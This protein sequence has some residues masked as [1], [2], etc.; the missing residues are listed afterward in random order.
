[1]KGCQC[2]SREGQY[3]GLPR[4][5]HAAPRSHLLRSFMPEMQVILGRQVPGGIK[6]LVK[7]KK[8]AQKPKPRPPSYTWQESLCGQPTNRKLRRLEGK[9]WELHPTL[10]PLPS[11]VKTDFL[12]RDKVAHLWVISFSFHFMWVLL[13]VFRSLSFFS[14][15]L[16][17]PTG[18]RL[19]D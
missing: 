7:T 6:L 12:C 5:G 4:N 16:L 15:F 11:V 1:M 10:L 17:G 8:E 13:N 18:M 19:A 2:E 9:G 3:W 14:F